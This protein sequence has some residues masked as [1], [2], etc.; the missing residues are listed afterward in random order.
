MNL[1]A[2]QKWTHSLWKPYGLQR[3]QM[4][5][6]GVDWAGDLGWNVLKLGC[7]DGYTTMNIIV[8]FI[9]LLKK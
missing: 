5:G 1:C 3:G 8:K 4:G 2:Q 7:D 6:G 9:K